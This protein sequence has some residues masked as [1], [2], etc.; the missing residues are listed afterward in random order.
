MD[1]DTEKKLKAHHDG[2]V[3]AGKIGVLAPATNGN[4]P[5]LFS[6]GDNLPE[7]WE[8]ALVNLWVNGC[9]IRTQY[10]EKDAKGAYIN[11]PS[12]DCTMVM[13]VETPLSEP[14]IHRCFPGGLEDLEE[15]RQEVLDGVK[16]HWV[17]DPND[18]SD[19]R[20]EYTYHERMVGYRV[21][22][23]PQ[24]IDQFEMM[25]QNIAKEPITRRAQMI[26][27]K[28]WEDSVVSD[29]ACW[30]SYWGRLSRDEKGVAHLNVNMRFRSRDAYKAAFMNDF[31]FILLAKKLAD[32]I[33]KL[34]GEEV[35]LAR[36]VDQSDSFHIY[37]S[38]F[39]E[40]QSTFIKQLLGRTFEER[41][42]RSDD[43]MVTEAFEEAKPVIVEKIKAEDEKYR[44]KR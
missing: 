43:E 38:Y 44:K 12:K 36:F 13:V 25:A 32:R 26:S 28:P 2:L 10:D 14:Y 8:N 22:G 21:P 16:D 20:W 17:R 11:P 30:Q 40:F 18:P 24:A 19:Q 33:S 41:T 1:G 35:K 9:D 31:A 7:A 29:P 6:R 15:Y 37:G 39:A 5:V 42:W 23:L 27:W 3:R 34:R 4:I